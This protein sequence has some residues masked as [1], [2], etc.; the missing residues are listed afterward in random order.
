MYYIILIATYT[1]EP[2]LAQIGLIVGTILHSL[3]LKNHKLQTCLTTWS[4]RW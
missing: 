2:I 4:T 3:M 1:I